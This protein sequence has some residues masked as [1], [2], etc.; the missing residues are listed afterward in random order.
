LAS[1]VD[2][3]FFGLNCS[4]IEQCW[5]VGIDGLLLR[6]QDG[7]ASWQVLNGET[8]MR[9]LEQ[10]GFGQAY[11]N[12][13]LYAVAV[14]GHFGVAVGE[15]GAIYLSEDD[16]ASWQRLEASKNWALPWF[17]DVALTKSRSGAI[18]GAKGQRIQIVDGQIAV[19]G[20]E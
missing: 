14:V 1:G 5:V 9:S 8:E 10:V 18:V 12:P 20:E 13:S 6:S 3:T 7:G 19:A 17:R 15:I 16:G 4:S 2:K 11:D